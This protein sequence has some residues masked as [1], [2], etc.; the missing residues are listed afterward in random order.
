[1]SYER[2]QERPAPPP[3]DLRARLG[4]YWLLVRG[5]RPIGTL[6]LLWPTWWALWLAADGLPPWHLLAI[7]TAG[8]WLTRSAGC[9]INDYADRWLDPHVERTRDRPLASGAVGGREALAVFAVLMLVAFGL[10]LLTNRLTVLLSVVGVVLAASYPYLKRYTYFPQVY[11]GIAFGWGIPMAFAAVQ[12]TVP[13]LAWLLLL[14]NVLWATA[15]D[16]WYAMVDRDD[17]LK[18]GAKSTA[19]LFGDADLAAQAL[20]YVAT[21]ATLALVGTRADLGPWFFGGLGVAAACVAWEFWICRRRERGPCFR[22]FLHNNWVG[23]AVFA[24]IAL[25]LWFGRAGVHGA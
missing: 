21:F 9:V 17:D 5:D 6:L 12:G 4:Q 13:A 14:A 20:L 3:F 23:A 15:Y 19:I 25:A 1:M 11:L 24:G 2:F 22:A 10:V 16:T 8:V 7:F 18:V